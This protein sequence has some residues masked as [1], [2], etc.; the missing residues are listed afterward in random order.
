MNSRTKASC[1]LLQDALKRNWHVPLQGWGTVMAA[2]AWLCKAPQTSG[3]SEATCKDQAEISSGFMKMAVD[4]V[5][6]WGPWGQDWRNPHKCRT[7]G[8]ES[9]LQP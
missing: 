3:L 1:C 6:F 8:Q 4:L 7:S 5:T 9:M 2:G